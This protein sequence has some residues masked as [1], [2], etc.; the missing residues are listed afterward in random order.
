MRFQAKMITRRARQCLLRILAT[1]GMLAIGISAASADACSVLRARH[2]NA[3]GMLQQIDS[4]ARALRSSGAGNCEAGWRE[5]SIFDP[6]RTLSHTARRQHAVAQVHHAVA[7][8][9]S[10]IRAQMASYG[11]EK[12][13]MRQ[14]RTRP[15]AAPARPVARPAGSAL[16]YCVRPSDG[17][18]FPAPNAQFVG[19]E[20]VGETR[21]RCRFIC[22][23]DG[24]DVYVL[25][26]ATAGAEAMI[27]VAD[28]SPYSALPAAFAYREK[29]STRRCDMQRYHDRVDE[30]RARAS[31]TDTFGNV[32]VPLPSARPDPV[33]ADML[34]ALRGSLADHALPPAPVRMVGVPYLAD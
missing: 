24:M 12:R 1:A 18:F 33:G 7:A 6:C 26:D 10:G 29:S 11:C 15:A 23:D 16:L 14:A 3:T 13:P 9:A 25:E 20:A 17:Y 5:G 2:A 30:A 34:L 19:V 22:E 31:T 27:S 8:R 21:D 28:R 32:T 4:E